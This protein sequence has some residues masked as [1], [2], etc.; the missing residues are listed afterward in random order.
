[1]GNIIPSEKLAELRQLV[2]LLPSLCGML[3]K[4]AQIRLVIDSSIIIGDLY[5]LVNKRKKLAAKTILQELI[6]SATVIAYA[7][8]ELKIEVE[9]WISEVARNKSTDE[10]PLYAEWLEYQKNLV[11]CKAAKTICN[12]ELYKRDP[13]DLPFVYVCSQVGAAA[14]ISKDADIQ[15][16]AEVAQ[17]DIIFTLR[18]YARSKSIEVTITLS[19]M[20]LVTT[21]MLAFIGILKLLKSLVQQL[22]QKMPWLAASLFVAILISVIH[23]KSRISCW[24]VAFLI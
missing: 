4:A 7:P 21:T 1:M 18:D 9:K 12:E 11:F 15:E 2:A 19:G 3:E 17:L 10:Q 24:F 13:S 16:T 5:W 6:A 20:V 8:L 14:I 22:V 23:P